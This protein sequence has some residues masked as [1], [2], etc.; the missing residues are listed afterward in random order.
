[1]D[2]EGLFRISPNAEELR[3]ARKQIESSAV[4]I[5]VKIVRCLICQELDFSRFSPHTTTN[6]LKLFF[7]TLTGTRSIQVLSFIVHR[8]VDPL[9]PL[10]Q[11]YFAHEKRRGSRWRRRIFDA[12]LEAFG[13]ADPSTKPQSFTLCCEIS[14]R[15]ASQ[16]QCQ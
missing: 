5:L 14:G 12:I 16:F 2:V 3:Q 6:L 9:Q 10:R 15:R 8:A 11:L 7:R 13:P 1:M 4:N